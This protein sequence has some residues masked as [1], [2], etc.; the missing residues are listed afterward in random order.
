MNEVSLTR[1]WMTSLRRL[2]DGHPAWV[3]FAAGALVGLLLAL[4]GLDPGFIAGTGGTWVRPDNDFVAY[5]V[6]WNYYV[7]DAWRFPLFTLPAMGYPEGGSVLF[8]D[9]LPIAA[10]PTKVLYQVSGVRVNPFGWWILLTYLLQ[11]AM[12]ARLAWAV[13]ARSVWAGAAAATLAVV[14]TSF[15]SRMGHTAL[16]SHFLV[17]WALALHFESLEKSRP[18][19]GELTILLGVTLLVNSYLFAMV[20]AFQCA[21]TFAV[22]LRR[23]LSF[24]DLRNTVLGMLVVAVMGVVAG[25]G[26]FLADPSTMKSQGFGHYSWNLVGLLLPPDGVFGYLAGLPRDGTHGQYEGESYIGRGALLLLALAIAFAP[27]RS[28][29]TVRRYW[30]YVGTLLLFAVYAASNVVY[31]SNVLLFEYPLPQRIL[32]LGNYFR[33]TGRFIWPLAYSLMVLPVAALFRWCPA[34]VAL[35]AAAFGVYLQLHEAAPGF[36]WRRHLTSQVAADLIDSDK[37]ESWLSQHQRIYQFPSWACGGLGGS[38]R[39]WGN[40]EANRELQVQLAAARAGLPTNSVYTS[41]LLKSCPLESTWAAAPS[42][43]PGVLYLLGPETVAASARLLELSRSNAC[44]TLDWAVVCSRSWVEMNA[45][46]NGE[47]AIHR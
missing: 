10:L 23:G 20:L 12:A 43:E 15:G 17:L 24:A 36:A 25:Y 9:A 42:L 19:V 41:R 3:C 5:V 37:I 14:N 35:P 26:V 38:K 21:T 40:L 31:A 44:V 28:L 34:G 2:V 1:S 29:S 45:L 22:W 18:K 46:S 39:S 4:R 47:S 11:G 30:V 13:G 16:S 32:D 27:R 33:A 7:V 8:N 6:A